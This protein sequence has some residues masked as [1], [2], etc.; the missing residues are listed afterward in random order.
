VYDIYFGTDPNPPL[1]AANQNLGPD[2]PTKSP[3]QYQTI[4][5][6]AL[7]PGTTYYWKIVSKT[8]ANLTATGPVWSFTTAGSG[9]GSVPSPWTDE[10]IGAVGT[11]GSASFA[12][13]TFTVSAS[14]A[15]IWGTADAFNYVS[16]PWTGD[17]SIVA[18]VDSV[19]AANQWS[20]AGVMF[21]ADLSAGSAQAFV[22]T[23]AAKGVAFQRRDA[24][25]GTSVNTSGSTAAPP[26][27]VRLDRSGNTFTAYESSDGAT[28]TKIGTDTIAMP[29]SIFVG[30]AVTSHDNTRVTTATLDAVTISG[31]GGSGGGLPS[32]WVD[33]DV[34]AVTAPGSAQYANGTFTINAEGADIWGTADAFHFV[35]Q[36]LAGD[37]SITAR[38]ASVSEANAWS[39][40]GVMIRET[41]S[42]GSAQAFMLVS[43]AK[44]VALQWRPT[45]GGTS[46]SASGSTSATPHWVRL[47]RSGN[48]ITG[49]ESADG[50]TWTVVGAETITMATNVYVGL[51]VTS[52]TTSASTTATIDSV[53]MP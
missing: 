23:S 33:Q 21:R 15:D 45:T 46:L 16:Q 28:W 52:H 3:K 30:L 17:G 26:H 14:G 37:G 25:G 12:N 51:A 29:A 11:A 40:A 53:S 4:A 31:G 2:D 34:G 22:L 1:F 18:R 24:P 20:K 19:T 41:L 10:D 42:A 50:S 7:T 47:V 27:W 32:P 5:L 44:G 43:A 38:V 39:K 49:Y 6:P 36:P 9:G 35:Y 48:T 8:M 13:G